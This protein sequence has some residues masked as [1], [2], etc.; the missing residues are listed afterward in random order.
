[1]P[2]LLV[3][4]KKT[5]MMNKTCGSCIC[6]TTDS[7]QQGNIVEFYHDRNAK[8]GFCSVKDF[9]YLV[10]QDTPACSEYIYDKE[11]TAIST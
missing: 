3:L 11:D 9:F 4:K 8:E 2:I 6:Y 10:E 1:M 5:K 7:D